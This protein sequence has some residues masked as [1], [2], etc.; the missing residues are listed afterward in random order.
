MNVFDASLQ[1]LDP[2]L[3]IAV[4]RDEARLGLS[5]ARV[6]GIVEALYA[7]VHVHST[8]AEIKQLLEPLSQCRDLLLAVGTIVLQL[9]DSLPERGKLL[10]CDLESLAARLAGLCHPNPIGTHGFV[11]LH[12]MSPRIAFKP[13][14]SLPVFG[15]CQLEVGELPLEPFAGF[16]EPLLQQAIR[17]LRSSL[18][19]GGKL[20]FE[21]GEQAH[22]TPLLLLLAVSDAVAK[23]CSV[24]RR[25]RAQCRDVPRD[26]LA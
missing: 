1:I 16:N 26:L 18:E 17:F 3:Q 5:E 2:V 19:R 11:Q 6:D 10:L 22:E 14:E 4:L 24:A 21:V 9:L 23:R 20:D 13:D 12:Q 7:P 25:F 8:A 15:H